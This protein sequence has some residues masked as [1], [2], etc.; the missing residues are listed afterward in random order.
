MSQAHKFANQFRE[1]HNQKHQNAPE[2]WSL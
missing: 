2:A 1:Q